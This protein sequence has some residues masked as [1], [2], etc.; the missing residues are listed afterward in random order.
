MLKRPKR[1]LLNERFT[2]SNM[3]FF[4][5][6]GNDNL[7]LGNVLFHYLRRIKAE[8]YMNSQTKAENSQNVFLMNPQ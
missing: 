1:Y 4:F 6:Q 2:Q 3:T 5:K 8:T 7:K